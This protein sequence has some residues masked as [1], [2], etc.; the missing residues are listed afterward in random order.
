[1]PERTLRSRA[2]ALRRRASLA[3]AVARA[4]VGSADL[5]VFHQL[6][7]PPSGGGHQFLRALIGELEG[8]GLHVELN[9][10]SSR[11]PACLFNSFNFDVSRLRRL[12]RDGCRLVHR[13][14]GPLAAY[15]GF[16]DGTDAHVGAVNAELAEATIVQSR[17]S[18]DESRSRGL[19]FREPVIVPNAV[20]PTIF[21]PPARPRTRGGKLRLVTTSWSDNPRKGGP[22][23]HWLAEHLDPARF[24]YTFVGRVSEPLPGA[25]V[26]PPQPSADVAEVLR[27]HDVFVTASL[28]DPCSNSL[29]EAL[30]C[31]LPA[32]YVESGGHPELVGDGGVGFRSTDDLLPALDRLA[33]ELDDR[34]ERIAVPSLAEVADR[35]LEVLG[36]A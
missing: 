33:D 31:G 11:T 25:R 22:T 17:F 23:Y 34:R 13:V 1:M 3:A 21:H 27:E 12:R 30:A 19:D 14:D 32:L 35:Y 29:L 8:R 7:P 20:D 26:V 36:I 10:L 5:A 28:S 16:D 9:R 15:R 2:G 18:L 4:P 24:E 6:E